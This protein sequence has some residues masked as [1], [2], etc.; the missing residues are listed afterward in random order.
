MNGLGSADVFLFEGF[1]LDRRAGVLSRLKDGCVA[2]PVKLGDRGVSLL[3]LLVARQGELVSK[4]E[5]MELVWQGRVVAEA[6]L[7]VQ[8]SHL[9]DI[10]GHD[11]IQTVTGHGYR[12]V[13]P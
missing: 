11:C 6:N 13:A 12:F 1:R 7:N 8:I 5:I 9:R 10:L 2:S 3:G 4:D